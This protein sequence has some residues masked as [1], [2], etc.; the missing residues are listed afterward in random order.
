MSRHQLRVI[1]HD[2][3]ETQEPSFSV[4]LPSNASL[5]EF[6]ALGFKQ[7]H[8]VVDTLTM[9]VNNIGRDFESIFGIP[10]QVMD[11]D[12][13]GFLE[14]VHPEDRN[15]LTSH[16]QTAL[17]Y[18][19]DLVVRLLDGKEQKWVWLR[20][21]PIEN[22]DLFSGTRMLFVVEDVTSSRARKQG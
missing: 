16:M 15:S 20:S 2:R 22:E 8:W 6:K 17:E 11:A 7:C 10:P 3:I 9:T 14:S 1:T 19:V 18:G 21:F 5:E 12:P 13:S 4:S